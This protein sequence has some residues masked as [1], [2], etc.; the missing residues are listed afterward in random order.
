MIVK[1]SFFSLLALTEIKVKTNG[2]VR[3]D[4]DGQEREILQSK[5]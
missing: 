1:L 3:K 2:G 5:L 4:K